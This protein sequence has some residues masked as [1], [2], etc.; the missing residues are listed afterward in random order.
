MSNPLAGWNRFWFTSR[1]TS[2]AAVVRIAGGLVLLGWTATV[3]RDVLS[4]FG[5][6]AILSKGPDYKLTGLKGIWSVLGATP[7]ATTVIAVYVAM[8]VAAACLVVGFRSRLAA[9][10]VFVA[11]VSFTRRN[12]LVFNSGDA[13]LRVI[14]F[15]LLL[16]PGGAALSV[17]RW[18][19]TRKTDE[20]FWDFPPRTVWPLRLMQIQLSIAYFTAVWDK[21]GGVTWREGSAVAFALRVGFLRRL[22]LPDGLVQSILVS[23]VLTFATL[24]AELGLAVLV[25]N[26]RYRPRI[27]LVGVA[28]H[29]GLDYAFRLGFFSY[30]MFVLYLA[31]VPPESMDA[32]LAGMRSRIGRRRAGRRPDDVASAEV[33][34]ADADGRSVESAPILPDSVPTGAGAGVVVGDPSAGLAGG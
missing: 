17:D 13:L 34:G 31:F 10:V 16:V 21:V 6:E 26:R 27:L 20:A 32:W 1:S 3:G 9:L 19:K 22:P 15:Y 28:L 8:L 2:T 5:P 7:S 4:F 29:L 23:N 25:W 12:P 18:R 24:A 33:V 14:S 30:S 11:M